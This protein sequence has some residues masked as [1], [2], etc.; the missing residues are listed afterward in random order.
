VYFVNRQGKIMKETNR[1]Q[2]QE[3]EVGIISWFIES[4]LLN[5]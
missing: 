5:V 2:Q 3:E 1:Q 4:W